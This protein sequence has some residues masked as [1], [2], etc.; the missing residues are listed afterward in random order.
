MDESRIGRLQKLC[1]IINITQF[2]KITFVCIKRKS[3]KEVGEK[4]LK[5]N[6]IYDYR[7]YTEL[8]DNQNEKLM[9]LLRNNL[10]VPKTIR[11]VL[12]GKK[13]YDAPTFSME[14]HFYKDGKR[15]VSLSY[16]HLI[17]TRYKD[18]YVSFENDNILED[19][20]SFT[21]TLRES[22]ILETSN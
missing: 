21:H 13:R 2:D 3:S 12:E 8:S 20:V 15:L 16:K 1:D 4:S 14:Y 19:F 9:S 10:Q 11:L 18:S 5:A 6:E 17:N 22:C 7:I